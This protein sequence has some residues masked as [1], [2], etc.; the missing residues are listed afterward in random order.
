MARVTKVPE[1]QLTKRESAGLSLKQ[2]R[3]PVNERG[4]AETDFGHR[5][6]IVLGGNETKTRFRDNTTNKQ[7]LGL[8]EEI[9]TMEKAGDKDGVQRAMRQYLKL[10]EKI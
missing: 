5:G 10:S 6:F 9:R 4:L 1:K 3:G 8:I 7:L 2:G